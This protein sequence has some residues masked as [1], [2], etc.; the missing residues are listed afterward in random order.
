MVEVGVRAAGAE[1]TR[2]VGLGNGLDG[3]LY[4]NEVFCLYSP[5]WWP[6]LKRSSKDK[7]RRTVEMRSCRTGWHV[8]VTVHVFG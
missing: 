4:D 8:K 3:F 6:G 7:K 2:V 5:P 1:A